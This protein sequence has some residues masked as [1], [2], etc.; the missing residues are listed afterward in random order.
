VARPIKS[1]SGG[2]ATRVALAGALIAEADFLL[3]D[4][5]TNNLDIPSQEFLVDWFRSTGIGSLVVTHDRAFLDAAVHEILEIDE[6]ART[7]TH[8][9]GTFSE[10]TE[11]KRI[12]FEARVREHE[13]REDRRGALIESARRLARRAQNFDSMSQNDYYRRRGKKVASMAVAQRT[14]LEKHLGEIPAPPPPARPRIPVPAVDERR[15]VAIQATDLGFGYQADDQKLLIDGLNL[16]VAF[17]ARV[18]VVGPN[19][20]GKSTL[21]RLLLGEIRP[22]RGQV[23]LAD[24]LRVAHLRQ[25]PDIRHPAEPLVKFARRRLNRSEDDVRELLGKVLFAD[26]V[27]L[28]VDQVS[29]GELR[30]VE[31]ATLLADAP[32]VLVLDEPTN[33]L[34]LPSLDM[35]EEAIDE[36]GG[37]LI[38]VSHDRR[39]L[40]H[41]RADQVI[42][43]GYANA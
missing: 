18:A 21:L 36:Y 38:A 26:T 3:L 31:L 25:K 34:D 29:M 24:P 28:R 40:E 4:E 43:L 14:R 15:G 7:L 13:E 27:H 37:S 23:T 8:F 10:F 32:D 33:H 1:L 39:F 11:H 20:S 41:V 17:G 42:S 12:E 35:V 22:D 19:G 16:R 5:P 2:E 6:T 9:G 30:R